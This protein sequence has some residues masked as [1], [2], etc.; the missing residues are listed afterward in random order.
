M[1]VVLDDVQAMT[2]ADERHVGIAQL[3]IQRLFILRV[4]RTGGFIQN[5]VAGRGQQHAC[6]DDPLLFAQ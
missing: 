2:D 6:E 4:Q 1:S 5:D 3:L